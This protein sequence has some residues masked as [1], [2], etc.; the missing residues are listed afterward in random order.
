LK[1]EEQILSPPKIPDNRSQTANKDHGPMHGDWSKG[2][3]A[4]ELEIKARLEKLKA[5][6]KSTT[7][8]EE[9]PQGVTNDEIRNR[10]DA[11][12]GEDPTSHS[13]PG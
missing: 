13:V 3:G 7:K 11:L 10:I 4:K 6:D 1:R 12:K 5:E 2:L 9:S 8:P